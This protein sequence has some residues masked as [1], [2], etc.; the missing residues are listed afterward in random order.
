MVFQRWQI[1]KDGGVPWLLAPRARHALAVAPVPRMP[2]QSSCTGHRRPSEPSG[3]SLE[4]V[5]PCRLQAALSA[6]S[7]PVRTTESS[8][9]RTVGVQDG[10]GGLQGSKMILTGG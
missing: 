6:G 3:P 10:G 4:R 1:L 8:V 9:V 2:Q 7:A 5:Q